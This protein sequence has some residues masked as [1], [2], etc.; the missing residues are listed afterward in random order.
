MLTLIK[1]IVITEILKDA[2]NSSV[3]NTLMLYLK[4]WGHFWGPVRSKNNLF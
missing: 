1:K 2:I 4:K 3:V